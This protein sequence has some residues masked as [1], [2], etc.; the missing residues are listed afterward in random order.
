[1]QH[2]AYISSHHVLV[3]RI[4]LYV[5]A[6]HHIGSQD[7]N[8]ANVIQEQVTQ[9]VQ[10]ENLGEEDQLQECPNH[11]ASVFEQGKPRSILPVCK[12]LTIYILALSDALSIGV[13][14]NR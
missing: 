6:S 4:R 3:H 10:L 11:I 2:F 1:M 14:C 9:E 7:E 5:L 12:N 8:P 13:E